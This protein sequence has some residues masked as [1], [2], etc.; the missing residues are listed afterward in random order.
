MQKSFLS[1]VIITALFASLA[2]T[3][4]VSCNRNSAVFAHASN[5]WATDFNCIDICRVIFL[6]QKLMNNL[7]ENFWKLMQLYP[8]EQ[9]DQQQ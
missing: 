4:S 8:V 7:D 5:K 6:K 9:Q 2:G 3:K 1:P